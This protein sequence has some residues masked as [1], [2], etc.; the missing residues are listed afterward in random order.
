MKCYR[1]L[2]IIGLCLTLSLTAYGADKATDTLI[3]SVSSVLNLP[4]D[5][6]NYSHPELPAHFTTAV[7]EGFDNTPENIQ[8]SDRIATLGR[9]LFYE[10]R[11]SANGTTSCSSCHTQDKGFADTKKLSVGFQGGLTGRNSM[12]LANVRFYENGHFFW[13]ERAATL[14]EQTLMPIQNDVEMGL[15]LEQAVANLSVTDYQPLLFQWAYGDPTITTTRIADSLSQFI[16]S[17]VSYQA[18]YDQGV[19]QNFR[20][21][22]A[23]EN[24]GRQLF[25]S[26][27]TNCA[28]CHVN[29]RNRG[30]RA[31]FQA[32]RAL[33]NGLDENIVND[34][35]GLG[36]ITGRQ[37]DNGRF[38]T[39]SLRNIALTA[40][41]MHDGRFANLAEVIEHY[42]SGVKA[43]PNLDNRLR[44]MERAGGQPPRGQRGPGGNRGGG[45]I[46]PTNPRRLNLND[47]EKQDLVL[48]LRTLTDTTFLTAEKFSNPF[49][50]EE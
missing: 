34:D 46:Q 25:F 48:F 23:S 22:S 5:I 15:T 33:N 28:A 4:N 17:L 37:R 40:P 18:K 6:P 38:K 26:R 24:R 36:D 12:G 20:N 2:P 10:K 16:R 21:F 44:R 41:Y 1:A 32:N 35:N 31:I 50:N 47:R 42:N 30:N 39:P 29:D 8:I 14:A 7:V 43:H 9:V 45:V 19:A 11:L 13:D 49:R 27:I 3:T